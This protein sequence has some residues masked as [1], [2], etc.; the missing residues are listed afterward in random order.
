MRIGRWLPQ[1]TLALTA[2][3]VMGIT[4][5]SMAA[6]NQE[7]FT[8]QQI[9]DT[10]IKNNP[11][12]IEEQQRW[13]EK[14]GR[15]PIV[16]AQPNPKFGIMKDDIP[17]SSKNPFDGMMTDFSLTQEIMNPV[18]LKKMG[19]MAE[20]DAL[21]SKA[22]YQG[23]AVAVYTDTKLAYYDLL[24]AGQALVI[25]KESQ[26]I[27]GQ[28]SQ[29]SQVNYSTGMSSLQ[30]TLK[31]QTEFSKMTIDLLNM[32]SME[33]VN[34]AKLN[35]LMGR[36][37]NA[38][39]Q[40][41]EEFNA[42]PPNFDLEALE[43]MA[44]ELKPAVLGM[45]YQVDMAQDGLELAK[46]QILPDYELQLGYKRYKKTDM[47]EKNTPNTWRIGVMAMIPLWDDKNKAQV[48]T[49]ASNLAASKASLQNMENMTTLDI[50]MALVEA[51]SA[52]RQIDL[53]KN[54]IIP[55]A[56]QSY[57]AGVVGY[58]NGKVDFMSVLDSLNALRNIRLD[59]YKAKINYEKAATNLEKAIGKPLFTSVVVP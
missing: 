59:Y 7:V 28:L 15:I 38:S 5:P 41:K 48:K 35:T 34:R 40:I 51:Q 26:Q 11:T 56:E 22:S 58:T 14:N 10:A 45:K 36:S 13:E 8:L 18:K 24:Y 19:T 30:D 6:E 47:P 50:Q 16:T 44:Q 39:L 31:A 55:Q 57:Q 9:L 32:A 17:T 54:T 12:I 53:Y 3:L 33:A 52:W 37:S 25:G 20:K 23:K 43:K 49:A 2:L 42:P 4:T 46:K 29:I 1:K 27:M 21:M